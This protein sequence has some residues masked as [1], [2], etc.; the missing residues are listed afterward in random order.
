MSKRMASLVMV[1]LFTIALLPIRSFAQ[2][3]SLQKKDVPNSVLAAFQK[4]Y[5]KAKIKGYSKEVERDTVIYEI[6]SVEGTVHRDATYAG[7]GRLI[8]IE[9]SLP[10]TDLPQPVRNTI[11]KEYP[12]GKVSISEKV[13]KG[14][15]I[16]F[17][18]LVTSGKLKHELVLNPDGSIVK[19]EKK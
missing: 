6:E 5:P 9:E 13:I 12:K 7:N 16:R 11:A 3:Q 4:S 18:V 19:S 14:S 15:A 1:V 8:S 2:E 17:E 10:F